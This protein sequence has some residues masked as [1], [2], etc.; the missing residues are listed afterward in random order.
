MTPPTSVCPSPEPK[1]R[2]SVWLARNF[3]WPSV[4]FDTIMVKLLGGQFDT[5][6]V[7]LL[8]GQFDTIMVKFL[9]GHSRKMTSGQ[10]LF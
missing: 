5:I 7:K 10:L 4:Q 2:L 9:G 1:I 8:G 6:M 3:D